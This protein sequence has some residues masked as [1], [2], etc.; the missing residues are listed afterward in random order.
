MLRSAV[1]ALLLLAVPAWGG[2]GPFETKA[3]KESAEYTAAC[4]TKLKQMLVDSQG[5]MKELEAEKARTAAAMLRLREEIEKL[6]KHL[7]V[8]QEKATL[9]KHRTAE[10]KAKGTTVEDKLDL[11]LK[12]LD[13]LDQRVRKLEGK[14]PGTPFD[15]VRPK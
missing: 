5:R 11:I 1:V 9:V 7:V 2:C 14:T 15:G 3:E 13:D 10:G 4:I 12:K 8:L 6:E